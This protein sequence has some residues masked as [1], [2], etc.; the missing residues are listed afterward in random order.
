LTSATAT[1]GVATA[2]PGTRTVTWNGA[3][4]SGA[5]VTIT[6]NATVAAGATPG[7]I[8][9][10]QG[11][12]HYDA[13]GDGD[14][15]ASGVTDDPAL[16]GAAD[17]TSFTVSGGATSFFRTVT[18][19][20]VFD[21]RE[22][23]PQTAQGA[24]PNPGP[25]QFRIQGDC[26]VPVGA[27]AITAN[28]TV[29]SPTAA[30]DLRLF[31]A[32]AGQPLVSTLNWSAGETAIANGAILPL[33]PVASPAEKDLAMAIGMVGSGAVHVIIDVTGYFR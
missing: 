1:G 28:V 26:G 21:T 5:S 24:L 18:P 27:T 4:A 7:T 22:P 23:G 17:P 19:C 16:P 3:L 11:T 30:G 31:P 33:A 20:R 12:T 9:S 8:V 14:N 32:S 2:D 13:N 29:V 15:E 25:H 6:V 10:N